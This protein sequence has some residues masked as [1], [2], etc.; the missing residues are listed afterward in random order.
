[1]TAVETDIITKLVAGKEREILPEWVDLLKKAGVLETGRLSASE[2]T[3]E[4]RNFLGFLRDAVAKGGVDV[5]N[6][7]YTP[8]RDF[9]ARLSRS[10]ASQGFS[11][12]ETTIFVF[13]LKEPL[14]NTLNRDKALSP[15]VLA[16]TTWAITLLVD[17]LGLYTDEV[18]QKSRDDVILRQQREI[19]ELSTPVVRLWDGVLA[20]P[21]IGT[22]DSQRTQVVM[23]NILHSIVDEGR[24]SDSAILHAPI[25]PS[26]QIMRLLNCRSRHQYGLLHRAN[27]VLRFLAP[28]NREGTCVEG[29]FKFFRG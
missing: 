10:R 5:A 9:L 14:F 22:L 3:V 11:P 16:Q 21:S 6:P 13:S 2:L 1:M 28:S 18:Y 7:A 8:V 23:E 20:L 15:A 25:R 12:R 4:C 27:G 29:G 26:H 17:E 19:A 24:L